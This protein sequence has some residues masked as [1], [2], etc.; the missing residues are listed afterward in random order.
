MTDVYELLTAEIGGL[1]IEY[2]RRVLE[3]RPW[4]AGQSAWAADLLA[5]LPAGPVL[6]LCSGAGH[7]G[8]LAVRPHDRALVQVDRSSA[9]CHHARVNAELAGMAERVE[10]RC[11]PMDEVVG[12]E[13]RYPMVVADP[14]WV[15][16]DRVGQFPEDPV[17]AIDGGPG[18]LD[19]ARTCLE[20]AARVLVPGGTCL[21][22]LGT[23]EQAEA[24][25]PY[26]GLV[27]GELRTFE[28][29]VVLRLDRP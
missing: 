16:A 18:G 17:S 8:L 9:A 12:A 26:A 5:D 25:A 14:P 20:V 7:I 4:T 24:L 3:P 23:A 27:A 6:E 29:G 22:Q 21:L 19:V 15:T 10:V 13:E 11:G 1:T 28:G 2:D